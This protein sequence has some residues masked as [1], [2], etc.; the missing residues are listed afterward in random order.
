MTLLLANRTGNKVLPKYN[1]LFLGL[2]TCLFKIRHVSSCFV[3]LLGEAAVYKGIIALSDEGEGNEGKKKGIY[4][5]YF[6]L[7]NALE[8][9]CRWKM[10]GRG[11]LVGQLE[12][13]TCGKRVATSRRELDV[14]FSARYS[15]LRPQA[16]LG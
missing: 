10:Y 1:C 16:A 9:S 5:F 3:R 4:P 12:G 6:C 14:N 15:M 2:K 13:E 7:G 11:C 8:R